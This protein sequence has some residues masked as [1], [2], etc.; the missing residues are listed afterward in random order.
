MNA[1]VISIGNRQLGGGRL[2][3]I[4]GPCV[5]E[6]RPFLIQVAQRI[7]EI[8][9]REGAP[10]IFKASYDKANRSS[11]QSFRGIGIEE[12][13]KLLQ[14]V[15]RDIGAPVT[16]DVHSPAE[17]ETAAP[18]ID[19]LQIPAFLCRQTDLI[20]AAASTGRVINVKKGQ[21]L[22]PWEIRNIAEKL[23][24]GGCKRY[25]FTERGTTFGYN[26]L[27]ADMR[28]IFWIRE[29]NYHVM[30]DATHAVQRPGGAGT[31]SSGDRHLVP[32]LARA[33]VAAGCDGV[34]LETHPN[35]ERALSDGLSQLPLSGL[36]SLLRTLQAIH[37]CNA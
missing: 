25:L 1:P 27:V 16:T 12:G 26:N 3:F 18:Y 13:C 17:V 9:D 4:L 34:F 6:S 14:E 5:I 10:F 31:S 30:F 7:R 2:L 35:P 8:C 19:M 29:M 36:A 24:K 22:S 11:L 37:L 28:S 21:F 32:V 15:G 20:L 33:A 23:E